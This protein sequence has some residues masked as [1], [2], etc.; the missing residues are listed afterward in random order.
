VAIL[1]GTIDISLIDPSSIRLEG[2]WPERN[3]VEDV[4]A[5]HFPFI[6]R[7]SPEGCTEAGPDSFEDLTLKFKAKDILSALRPVSPG[8]IR[9]L[10]VT[11]TLMD[12]TPLEG[13]DVVII[14]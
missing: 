7:T 10:H 1:G 13:E 12:G 2:V 3:S 9:V 5:P 8:D 4:T 6:G 11:G 14:K